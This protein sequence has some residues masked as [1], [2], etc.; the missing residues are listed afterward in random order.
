[1]YSDEML[2]ESFNE[3]LLKLF[4][5]HDITLLYWIGAGRCLTS[6]QPGQSMSSAGRQKR[7]KYLSIE[8]SSFS[9]DIMGKLLLTT[10]VKL[11]DFQLVDFAEGVQLPQLYVV[12]VL[13]DD[14]RLPALRV[15]IPKGV[16]AIL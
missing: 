5:Y 7:Y 8:Q 9:G 15:G 4:S 14:G 12:A 16:H 1:M 6:P 2:L 13:W 10:V 3:S 11:V